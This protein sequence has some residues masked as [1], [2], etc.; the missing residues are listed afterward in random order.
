MRNRYLVLVMSFVAALASSSAAYA[1]GSTTHPAAR[2]TY[3]SGQRCSNAPRPAIFD[4]HDLTGVWRKESARFQP[5]SSSD[6]AGRAS[7]V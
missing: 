7:A 1:Q 4:K 3:D 5:E 2:E 6:D